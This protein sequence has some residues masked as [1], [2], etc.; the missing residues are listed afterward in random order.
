V[1]KTIDTYDFSAQPSIN[2]ALVRELLRGEYLDK[3]ENVLLIGTR[4][5]V[6]PTGLC[7]GLLSLCPRENR[8]LLYGHGSG[9]SACGVPGRK[10]LQRMHK[11][12]QR[13]HLLVIDE[14]GYVP[15][16]KAGAELL[17]EVISRPMN[18]IA[19]W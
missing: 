8:S 12:L 14:L 7:L 10:R 17:F 4:E 19:S 1:I 15:F 3:R 9:H 5:P 11:Q 18:T 2:E 16:S 6:K 13:V